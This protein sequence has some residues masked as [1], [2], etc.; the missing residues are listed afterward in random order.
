MPLKHQLLT[1][2]VW[3]GHTTYMPHCG[4]VHQPCVTP[5]HHPCVTPVHQP[6]V[7]QI[8]WTTQKAKMG[9]RDFTQTLCGH[10]A[11]T[12]VNTGARWACLC[13]K[14]WALGESSQ[15]KSV[16]RA[17]EEEKQRLL[18][19]RAGLRAPLKMKKSLKRESEENRKVRTVKAVRNGVKMWLLVPHNLWGPG[20]TQ[21]T[22]PTQASNLEVPE[23][24]A[25]KLAASQEEPDRG[26]PPEF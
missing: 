18:Q 1:H 9:E 14:A 22:D 16:L 6:C 7:I 19:Q 3:T 26:W 25:D 5:V 2:T 23:K 24:W 4:L 12:Q 11:C 13:Y 21:Q 15:G 17:W 10:S 20:P 8:Q